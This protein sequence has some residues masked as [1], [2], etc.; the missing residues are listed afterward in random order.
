VLNPDRKKLIDTSLA[1]L[2]ASFG[3]MKAPVDDAQLLSYFSAKDY[4]SMVRFVR[5]SL[6]LT[7]RVRVGVYSS[8]GIDAPAWV[9]RPVPLPRYGT[10]EF[11]ASI[12]TVN[13]QRSFLESAGFEPAVLATAH[14]LSHIVLDATHHTL[15][16]QEE[17]VDLT[18]ML[19]GYRDFYVTGCVHY[20]GEDGG[21]FARIFSTH[22]RR[23]WRVGYLSQEE[24]RYAAI[25]MSG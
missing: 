18:A 19:L 23:R 9:E 2:Q 4:T 20:R 22:S 5:S 10:R 3:P 6:A 14:E 13:F 11:D 1:Q 12:A 21:I 24:V 25:K 8:G 15:R 17:A 7:L 16:T